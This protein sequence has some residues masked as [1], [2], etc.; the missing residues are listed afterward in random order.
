MRQS[1]L[2]GACGLAFFAVAAVSG[3]ALAQGDGNHAPVCEAK[4]MVVTEPSHDA[5]S[6]EF[7]P[8]ALA[9]AC[10]DADGDRLTVTAVS[11]PAALMVDHQG[12]SRNKISFVNNLQVG[13]SVDIWYW[14]SDG[15]GGTTSSSITVIRQNAE[16]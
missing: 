5:A 16:G 10:I 12:V 9:P 15:N 14:V 4:T 13:A 2:L 7:N 11:Q 3:R 1:R 8:I 6:I